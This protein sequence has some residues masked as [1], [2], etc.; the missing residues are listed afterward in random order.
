MWGKDHKHESENTEEAAAIVYERDD[1]INPEQTTF[2]LQDQLTT[3][4]TKTETEHG[5]QE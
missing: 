1:S 5:L 3:K 2:P 4:K